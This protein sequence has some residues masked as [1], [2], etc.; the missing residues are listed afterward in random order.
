MDASHHIPGA[1]GRLF[2]RLPA[3]VIEALREQ[4]ARVGELDEQ[5]GQIERRLR[6]W[7]RED[8]AT[9]RIAAIPGVGLLSATAAVA[10]ARV[11]GRINEASA[12][13][14]GLRRDGEQD[15]TH[16]LGADGP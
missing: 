3:M 8:S 1:L 12:K 5:I 13:K 10:T 11:V 7:Q 9:Q 15:G 4:Y 6:Q 14:C 16:D 2:D